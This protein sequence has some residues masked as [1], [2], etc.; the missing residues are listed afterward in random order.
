MQPVK[1]NDMKDPQ[2]FQLIKGTFTPAEAARV[3]LSLVKSKIDYHSLEKLSNEERFGRDVAHSE[4]RLQELKEL[5]IEL[6]E[7]FA[8]ATSA[9]QTLKIKGWIEITPE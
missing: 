2:R 6:K 3:L 9:E 4:K 8:A 7:V 1:P 5:Q